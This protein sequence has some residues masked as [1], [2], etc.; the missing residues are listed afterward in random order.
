MTEKSLILCF[1][2]FVAL[3]G[4]LTAAE[5]SYSV[6]VSTDIFTIDQK[7]KAMVGP[8]DVKKLTLLEVD[9]PELLWLTE[10]QI[11]AVGP[12]GSEDFLCHSFIGF[13]KEK[14]SVKEHN[15]LF[16][17]TTHEIIE[18][19]TYQTKQDVILSFAQGNLSTV[20]PEGFGMPIRSDEPLSFLTVVFNQ[21]IEGDPVQVKFK[22]TV[23]FQKDRD[24]EKH[25]KPLF[26]RYL[27]IRMERNGRERGAWMVRPGRHVYRYPVH[28]QLDL[29]FDTSFHYIQAHLHA[30][31]ESL[32]LRDLTTGES[33]F[34]TH[35]L[36]YEDRIGIA[37]MNHFSSKE[38]IPLYKNHEYELVC[39]YNNTSQENQLAMA[40][41]RL[42]LL[43]KDFRRSA[44]ASR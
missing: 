26:H 11:K 5:D 31:A 24:L 15:A 3:C 34:K 2:F 43:N 14:Y 33:V 40:R 37:H 8:Q 20:F 42:Y 39:V 30:F 32:E 22:T 17:N 28:P 13:N 44:M 4:P 35:V 25:M 18:N 41:F 21:N 6:E 7:Y 36:N 23:T 9:E 27:T 38:G 12:E 10:A 29:P 1:F 16:G 19:T